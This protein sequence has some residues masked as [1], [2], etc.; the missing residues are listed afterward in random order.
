MTS[1]LLT[2]AGEMSIHLD[3]FN[4]ALPHLPLAV[5]RHVFEIDDAKKPMFLLN[6]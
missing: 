5:V 2:V 4:Q 1:E 3:V 6:W